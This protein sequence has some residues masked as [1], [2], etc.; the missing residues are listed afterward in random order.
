MKHVLI[1]LLLCCSAS[2]AA[3]SK[4]Y[5][6]RDGEVSFTS[7]APLELIE[8]QSNKL[9]GAIDTKKRTFAFTI[10]INSFQG[11]NSRLQQVHFNENY[12]ESKSH[13]SATFTGKIIE[14]INFK[15]EGTYHVR[16]KGILSIHGVKQERIIKSQLIIRDNKLIINSSFTVLL[17]EHGIRIP[18]IV[19]Q[20]ISE[21]IYIR[22]Q[23]TLEPRNA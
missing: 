18:K 11:F 15:K 12:L 1:V 2:L 17:E 23:A 10:K 20:K 6:T 8:A 13:P 22:I 3:Q 14:K 19:H 7:D 21:L 4:I 16:T 5:L 9:R